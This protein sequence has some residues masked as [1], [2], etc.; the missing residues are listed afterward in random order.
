MNRRRRLGQH[1]LVDSNVLN[2]ILD[3]AKLGK[4]EVVYEI[5]TGNG[6]LTAE[7]CTRAGSVISCDVDKDMI[8]ATKGILPY[9]KSRKA[10]EWLAVRKFNRAVV[11][12][13]KEFAMKILSNSGSN[14]RAVSAL[15]Q[16]C[17]DMEIIMNVNRN[18]FN[19]KP[20][21]DSILLKIIQK[22][23]VGSDVVK[24]LKFLFSYRGKKVS[25]VARKFKIRDINNIDID[26][27]IEQLTPSEAIG[28]ATMIEQKQKQLLQTVR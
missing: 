19:P 6:I 13:Q 9:S 10:L 14:Y 1:L 7:L 3:S 5:G 18:S 27:R 28:L 23:R 21:V 25:S 24:A 4:D 2:A 20:R 12:V 11:M 16:H 8:T 22:R 17:F 15:A 26:K